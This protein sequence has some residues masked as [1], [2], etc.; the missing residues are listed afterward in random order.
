MRQVPWWPACSPFSPSLSWNCAG[1]AARQRG[2][3][4]GPA[5]QPIGRP[6]ALD[7]SKIAVAQRMHTSGESASIIATT[8]AVSRATPPSTA[9]SAMMLNSYIAVV[10][11]TCREADVLG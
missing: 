11:G 5:G 8:P 6:K 3:R 10:V 4:D 1:S 2:T 7:Q 9:C